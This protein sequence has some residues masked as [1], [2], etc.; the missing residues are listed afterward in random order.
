MRRIGIVGSGLTGAVIARELAEK[1]Y[2]CLVAD[3]RAQCGGNCHTRRDA[4][5]G[6][7]VHIYGPH[8]FHTKDQ[9]VWDYVRRFCDMMPY[10]NRVKAVAGGQVY[11]LPINLHTINQFFQTVLSPAKARQLLARKSRADIA[12]PRNFEEQALKFVGEELYRAF[13]EGYTRKQWGVDPKELPASILQ[14]L[15]VRFTY[16]DNY[17]SHPFQGIPKDGYTAL[18][19][20]ILAHENIEVSLGRPFEAVSESFAHVFYSGPLDRYFGYDSGRLT[21]RTLD[22]ETIRADG[23]FQGTAV[24]NYPDRDVPFTRCIEHK[25]F[26]PWECATFART[27]VYREYSRACGEGDIPYYPV[28]LVAAQA[29]LEHYEARARAEPHV[30][31]VGRLGTYQYL[32]MDRA[33]A[34]ALEAAGRFCQA[35]PTQAGARPSA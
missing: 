19:E 29:L 27:V 1:G 30:T 7:M 9:A 31:F 23:D 13:F 20:A 8:I 22:F 32:D 16:D 2:K 15:P 18:I 33:V 25:F 14:R 10:V 4:D 17:F 3:E 34:N 28:R 21:Y 5:T 12:V 6:V 24:I 26:A 11:G 35:P